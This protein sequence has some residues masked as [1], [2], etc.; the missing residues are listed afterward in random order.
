LQ[1][2]RLIYLWVDK[3]KNIQ[4]E[5]LRL[6]LDYDIKVT[7][8]T[9]KVTESDFYGFGGSTNIRNP[10]R[11]LDAFS[12]VIGENG[13]GKSHFLELL[14]IL[15]CSGAFPEEKSK[16]FCI[17]EVTS[18]GEKALQLISNHAYKLAV[19]ER[20]LKGV[21]YIPKAN[22]REHPYQVIEYKPLWRSYKP[23]LLPSIEENILTIAPNP[24]DANSDES[25]FNLALDFSK[26][27]LEYFQNKKNSHACFLIQYDELKL[28]VNDQLSEGLALLSKRTQSYKV[29]NFYKKIIDTDT[30]Y[31]NTFEL[32]ADF[33]IVY[34]QIGK[35]EE[36]IPSQKINVV[37]LSL[38]C[39]FLKYNLDGKDKG[40]K[41]ELDEIQKYSEQFIL[42]NKYQNIFI[43]ASQ[44]ITHYFSE[45][46]VEQSSLIGST[47][48][49]S[50]SDHKGIRGLKNLV[51]VLSKDR[52]V[53]KSKGFSLKVDG[54]SSGEINRISL[55][56]GLKEKLSFCNNKYPL[57]LF[58]E[59]DTTFHPEWQRNLIADIHSIITES[60]CEP[61]VVI[62]SHSP[63]I[64]SDM[65]SDKV[66]ALQKGH[67]RLNT[68]AANIH[69]LLA[70]SFFLR[71]TIGELAKTKIRLVTHF[72]DDPAFNSDDLPDNFEQRFKVCELIVE[73]I[74]DSL[75]RNELKDRLFK[76]RDAED[77]EDDALAF[78]MEHRDDPN[79]IRALTDY[80]K[81]V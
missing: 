72:I 2:Y 65:L 39:I 27:A 24:V 3:Y 34:D 11:D 8:K 4:D 30:P 7:G 64:L 20:T 70:D 69:E 42:K 56:H 61:Q 15:T 79:F 73:Q 45:G 28:L 9:I 55:L 37:L 54:L 49:I 26:F 22:S 53:V 59:A 57:V 10:L 25:T 5:K 43:R 76:L 81:G 29:L 50:I 66:L 44:C 51:D 33:L 13:S 14:T 32:A 80:K 58:D 78:F 16:S 74:A 19:A 18:N 23:E 52:G 1:D 17:I 63:L 48:R 60:K 67:V 71:N 68:F 47:C 40:F 35:S 46:L 62:A 31:K 6:S 75:L 38:A 21:A 12:A 36:L 77:V 41:R